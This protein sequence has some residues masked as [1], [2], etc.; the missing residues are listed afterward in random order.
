ML[1]HAIFDKL[2][3]WACDRSC[4]MY[5]KPFAKS[6]NGHKAW[7]ALFNHYFGP[8][9][10]QNQAAQ[11]EKTLHALTYVK[12]MRNFMFETYVMKTVEQ[13]VILEGLTEYGYQGIDDGTK[14][15]LF[16]EGI[17]APELEVVKTHILSDASLR[18]DFKACSVLFKDFFKQKHAAQCLPT[19]MIAQVN[20]RKKCRAD[21]TSLDVTNE[22]R[23]FS[24]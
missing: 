22:D 23:Y 20:A 10:V 2:A 5:I 8:N 16:L 17:M 15:C 19:H 14:V 13:H 6:F 18:M 11:A 24:T 21:D 3:A 4:W 7:M 9:N 12:E 1:F